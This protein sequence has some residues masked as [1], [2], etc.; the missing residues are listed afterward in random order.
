MAGLV[1]EIL[2]LAG[3]TPGLAVSVEVRLQTEF[4]ILDACNN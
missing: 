4:K 3:L 2:L 1:Y